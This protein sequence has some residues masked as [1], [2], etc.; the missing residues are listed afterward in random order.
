M[1]TRF[2]RWCEN[3]DRIYEDRGYLLA[4]DFGTSWWVKP[5]VW[6]TIRTGNVIRA[7]TVVEPDGEVICYNQYA[8]ILRDTGHPNA[9][10]EARYTF[11]IDYFR[12]K[13][14]TGAIESSIAVGCLGTIAKESTEGQ[15][16]G[17]K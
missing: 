10:V 4:A 13:I 7:W 3:L 9:R 2:I 11:D 15:R 17:Q 1:F 14:W 12:S 5:L 6:C 16:F 8:H